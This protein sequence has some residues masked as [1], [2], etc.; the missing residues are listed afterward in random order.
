MADTKHFKKLS[1]SILMGPKKVKLKVQF[2][3]NKYHCHTIVSQRQ[4]PGIGIVLSRAIH[5]EKLS[6]HRR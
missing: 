2:L 5:Y 3:F 4:Q 1:Y 6:S